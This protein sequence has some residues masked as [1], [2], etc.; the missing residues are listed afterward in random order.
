MLGWPQI[1]NVPCN[2]L[3]RAKPT[4]KQF[5]HSAR[6][7]TNFSAGIL[8]EGGNELSVFKSGKAENVNDEKSIPFFSK[9][10]TSEI[11]KT[12]GLDLVL[13]IIGPILSIISFYVLNNHSFVL[14][15]TSTNSL[16]FAV[17]CYVITVHIT[18]IVK[19]A[20]A[21]QRAYSINRAILNRVN[22]VERNITAEMVNYNVSRVKPSEVQ[23]RISATITASKRVRNTFVNIK[24]L[25]GVNS[26]QSAKIISRYEA[27]LS[28]GADVEWHDVTGLADFFDGRYA[29]IFVGGTSA[30]VGTHKVTILNSPTPIVNFL[31]AAPNDSEFT[32]AYFGWISN[33]SDNV[34]VFHTKDGALIN[35]FNNYFN[36]L[37]DDP[38]AMDVDVPYVLAGKE[39][40][41]RVDF[42]KFIGR[43]ISVSASALQGNINVDRE[44]IDYSVIDI[45]FDS[46]WKL[47]GKFKSH[48]GRS[49]HIT[50]NRSILVKDTIY[51]T[52]RMV[53]DR[54]IGTDGIGGWTVSPIT[55]S[56]LNARP[57][58]SGF[59]SYLKEGKKRFTFAFKMHDGE[60]ISDEFVRTVVR[61]G[62][63]A[64]KKAPGDV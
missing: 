49:G 7:Q 48:K 23:D 58:L 60:V 6:F 9:E 33:Q 20:Q 10:T 45:A 47:L 15:G 25:T 28:K 22:E 37:V 44:A 26:P 61:E 53:D 16:I 63:L 43:W 40:F 2:V 8:R 14:G 57:R 31:L 52:Y 64:T 55:A 50:S 24:H 62:G 5:W 56:S 21:R 17:I 59:Y 46:R 42:H 3:L 32:D 34:E 39:R 36:R 27:Y 12:L 41:A 29:Q 11:W 18:E 35:L 19:A 13:F 1:H 30:Q 51:Y 54:G 38:E 4:C